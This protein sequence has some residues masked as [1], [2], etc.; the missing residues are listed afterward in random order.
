MRGK[1][2]KIAKNLLEGKLCSSCSSHKYN[3]CA[4]GRNPREETCE[5]W[6]QQYIV[7]MDDTL[8]DYLEGFNKHLKE[9]KNEIDKLRE[10]S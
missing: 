1:L 7:S 9:I 2:D 5:R 4:L 3:M 10:N 8:L 6:Q